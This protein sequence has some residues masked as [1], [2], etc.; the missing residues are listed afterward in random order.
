MIYYKKIVCWIIILFSNRKLYC[1]LIF[2]LLFFLS[3]FASYQNKIQLHLL[4]YKSTYIRLCGIYF[5][6][7][8]QPIINLKITAICFRIKYKWNINFWWKI[9]NKQKLIYL[10]EYDSICCLCYIISLYLC[11]ISINSNLNYII[12]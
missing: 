7:S 1:D 12:T 6:H 9:K 8:Y 10:S 2:F 4:R 5:L 11:F 3:L